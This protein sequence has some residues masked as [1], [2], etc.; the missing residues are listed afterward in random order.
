MH[1]PV[2]QPAGW[3]HATMLSRVDDAPLLE[4]RKSNPPEHQMGSAE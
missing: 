4:L 1:G 2:D 3:E